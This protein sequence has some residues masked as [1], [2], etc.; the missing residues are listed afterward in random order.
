MLML[1]LARLWL[2]LALSDRVDGVH[3]GVH[4]PHG[5]LVVW[6]EGGVLRPRPPMDLRHDLF[7]VAELGHRLGVDERC[8]FDTREAGLREQVDDLDLLLGRDEIRLD[9]EPVTGSDFADGDARGGNHR[10]NLADGKLRDGCEI[11]AAPGRP[12][13]GESG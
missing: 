8:H 13:L 12:A 11:A 6:D 10:G 1:T 3:A 4:R 7:C 5:A 2:S 9:L